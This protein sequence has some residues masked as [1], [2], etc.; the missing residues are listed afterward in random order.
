ML[1]RLP[2]CTVSSEP[3]LFALHKY[4]NLIADSYDATIKSKNVKSMSFNIG[5]APITQLCRCV[6]KI[7]HIQVILPCVEIRCFIP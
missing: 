7:V 2:S 3:Y 4:Q 5:V 1:A 6:M